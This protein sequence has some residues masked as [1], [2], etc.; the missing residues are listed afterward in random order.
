MKKRLLFIWMLALMASANVTISSLSAAN[1]T[2]VVKLGDLNADGIVNVADITQL[3]N[4][5]NSKLTSQ[6]NLTAADANHDGVIN[7]DDESAI[8]NIILSGTP[9]KSSKSILFFTQP[10]VENTF[11]TAFSNP[12]VYAGSTGA[13]T[14]SA[15][16]DGVVNVN[17]TTGDVSYIGIGQTTITATLAADDKYSGAKAQYTLKVVEKSTDPDDYMSIKPKARTD[18]NGGSLSYTGNLIALVTAG[19]SSVGTIYYNITT[20]NV[21]PSKNDEGWTTVTPSATAAGTYYVWY[22]VKCNDNTETAICGTPIRVSI[23]NAT[24][25][26]IT[27][28]D[29]NATYDGN[30]HG[31]TVSLKGVAEGATIKYGT[32]EGTYNLATSPTYTDVTA[33]AT[34]YYQVT[35]SNYETVTGSSTVTITHKALSLKAKD[36]TITFGNAIAEGTDQVIVDGLVTGDALTAVTLTP[37]GTDVTTTGTITPSAAATAN[38]IGNYTV[39]YTFGT[40]TI[41][42]APMVSGVSATGYNA[43]Y[44]GAAHGITVALSGVAEG[45]TIKYGTTEGTYNLTSSPTYTDVTAGATVYYQVTKSNYETV[46]GSS[47]VT[48]TH[49]ALSISAKDQTIT[50]GNT[51]AI[52]TDQVIVD[53]LVTGDALTAVTLTPSGTDVTTT[54]NIIPSAATTTNGI[55]NYIVAY[56][57]GR[58][59]ITSAPMVSGVSVTGYNATYD[60]AAHGIAVVLNGVAEGATIKY[61]T[62]EGSYNLTT[63]PTFTNVTDGTIVY[64]QE[65]LAHYETVTGSS[66]ETITHKT[67]SIKAKDQTIT[68]GNTIDTSTDQVIV[69]GLVTGDALTAVTLT[70]SGTDVTTTGTITPSAAA[71]ANGVDNY[72]VTYTFGTLTIISAPMVSGVSATGYNATY[73]GTAHGITVSL[74]GVAEGA[75]IKYGTTEGSYNLTTSPT[76]TD[77]TDGTTV[78]Y[79]VTKSNFE[80]VTGSS[81]VI[82]AKRSI[83]ISGITANNKIYDGTTAANLNY[84]TITTAMGLVNGDNLSVTATGTFSDANAGDGKTVTISDLTLSGSSVGNY[85]LADSNQ[86]TYTTANISKKTATITLSSAAVSLFDN[87]MEAFTATLSEYEAGSTVIVTTGNASYYTVNASEL[88]NGVSTITITG[89]EAG[90]AD[91]TVSASSNNFIYVQVTIPITVKASPLKTVTEEHLGYYVCTDGYYYS[92]DSEVPSGKTVAGFIAYVSGKGHGLILAKSDANSGSSADWSTINSA[93]SSYTPSITS[94]CVTLTWRLPSRTDWENMGATSGNWKTLSSRLSALSSRG[95]STV[96]SN[97]Y[98]NSS[99]WSSTT[100]SNGFPYVYNFNAKNWNSIGSYQ[101]KY[102][103]ACAEF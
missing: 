24:L 86:Q 90:S 9:D 31:I 28:T 19:E 5:L 66:T 62:T 45:A 44:D 43:T 41:T 22:Y 101:S 36:Q 75:T 40:L 27:V 98:M 12:V 87:C 69:D 37:S 89:V 11:G 54:G 2:N 76:Y 32:T 73:D 63:S 82:I 29:Y 60:G 65:M 81:T 50:F 84:P 78:Y 52:G 72:I 83:S 80:T 17:S 51:I 30:P 47:T 8:A 16:P 48:I 25:T 26:G 1:G 3:V 88:N 59:T 33:G 79:Q 39:T 71:T 7:S 61:G 55:D 70:P 85:K 21:Q 99:Y 57:T 93:C 35:K 4:Y 64:Y 95:V 46:T 96:Q 67:L 100:T 91:C 56:T 14:Y 94:G 6:I 49:K 10:T 20:V 103:R 68:F 42:G 15:S 58:L 34:V 18:D 77:V 53:G 23:A 102:G 13:I 74:N 92:P 97:S 38:G